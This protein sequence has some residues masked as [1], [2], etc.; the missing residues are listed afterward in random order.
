MPISSLP[1]EVGLAF[2]EDGTSM[3]KGSNTRHTAIPHHSLN[4]QSS[5]TSTIIEVTESQ[6]NFS[7]V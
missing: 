5:G 4:W 2:D 7:Y 1:V 6:H 3:F